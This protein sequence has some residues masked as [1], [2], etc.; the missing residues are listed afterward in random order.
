M[1]GRSILEINAFEWHTE[2][3]KWAFEGFK[4]SQAPEEESD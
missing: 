4:L 2:E 3:L 1:E